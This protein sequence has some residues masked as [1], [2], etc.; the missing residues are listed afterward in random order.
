MN[1]LPPGEWRLRAYLTSRTS[2][3][4]Y[5]W[6]TTAN[7]MA[8]ED[9]EKLVVTAWRR[10]RAVMVAWLGAA[11]RERRSRTLRMRVAGLLGPPLAVLGYTLALG[12]GGRKKKGR[13]RP[14]PRR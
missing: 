4:L 11:R 1:L 9:E 10:R 3:V 5:L 12:G 8:Q 6:S 2:E 7:L 13:R 14:A